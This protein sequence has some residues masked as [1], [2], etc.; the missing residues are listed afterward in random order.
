MSH[1]YFLWKGNSS[2][3]YGIMVSEYPAI[4]R[5]KE[6]VNQITIPRAGRRADSP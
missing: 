5:P 1:P 2:E 6:R 3:D 4:S